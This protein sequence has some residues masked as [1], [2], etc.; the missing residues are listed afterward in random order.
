MF[1]GPLIRP[2]PESTIRISKFNECPP[3]FP[4]FSIVVTHSGLN[5]SE[6]LGKPLLKEI[7]PT[8]AKLEFERKL[9]PSQTNFSKCEENFR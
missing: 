5:Y 3:S 9:P 6:E 7:I 2:S 4:Q 8:K 1:S